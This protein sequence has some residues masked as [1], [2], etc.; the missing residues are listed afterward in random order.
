MSESNSSALKDDL[1][2]VDEKAADGVAINGNSGSADSDDT[3]ESLPS[4]PSGF[5]LAI[6][7]FALCIATFCVA[8]DN[9][10]ISTAIPRITDDFHALQDIGW[11]GSG[12]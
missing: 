2:G 4:H 5:I 10:I 3:A 1:N 11:Y 8:L 9:T 7:I 6:T 12:K